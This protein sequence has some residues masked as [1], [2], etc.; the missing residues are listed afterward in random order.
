MAKKDSS[1]KKQDGKKK[2]GSGISFAV[3]N[4][5]KSSSKKGN[6][7][8]GCPWGK[9]ELVDRQSADNLWKWFLRGGPWGEVAGAAL[10]RKHIDISKPP[11]HLIPSF[12]TEMVIPKMLARLLPVDDP[13]PIVE[14]ADIATPAEVQSNDEAK[15]GRK[16]RLKD[17]REALASCLKKADWIINVK[18]KKEHDKRITENLEDLIITHALEPLKFIFDWIDEYSNTLNDAKWGLDDFT[19]KISGAFV[20]CELSG[21]DLEKEAL[22]LSD[23]LEPCRQYIERRLAS[24]TSNSAAAVVEETKEPAKEE[25]T[26][27]QAKEALGICKRKAEEL[28]SCDIEEEFGIDVAHALGCAIGRGFDDIEFIFERLDSQPDLIGK[29]DEALSRFPGVIEWALS[30]PKV[31]R[32]I[33]PE[34]KEYEKV[35]GINDGLDLCRQYVGANLP[36]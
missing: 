31:E 19:N 16:V 5:P 13:A 25:I 12:S 9:P 18:A 24:S 4:T 1:G 14:E 26:L 21:S 22:A 2:G 36:K 23:M 33:R 17:A 8:G 6:G 34:Y 15:S 28:I 3:A 20:Y 29:A 32:E 30:D 11:V 27:E 10:V 7:K 35:R